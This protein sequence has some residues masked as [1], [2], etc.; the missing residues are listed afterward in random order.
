MNKWD[1]MGKGNDKRTIPGFQFCGSE[2]KGCVLKQGALHKDE[3]LVFS[4][5]ESSVKGTGSGS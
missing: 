4:L 1:R 3:K 5:N 2:K